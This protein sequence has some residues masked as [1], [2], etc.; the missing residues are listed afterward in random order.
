MK[1]AKKYG[2]M[3]DVNKK[4]GFSCAILSDMYNVHKNNAYFL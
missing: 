1:V 2:I 4:V 3:G